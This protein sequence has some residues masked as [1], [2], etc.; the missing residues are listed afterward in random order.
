MHS[1]EE[2]LIPHEDKMNNNL[3]NSIEFKKINIFD[4][5][6]AF[7]QNIAHDLLPDIFHSVFQC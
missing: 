4:N 3:T 2:A 5:M 1:L 6:P 7:F